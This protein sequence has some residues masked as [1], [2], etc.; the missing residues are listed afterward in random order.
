MKGFAFA[1]RSPLEVG[2]VV[3]TSTLLYPHTR[4]HEVTD[5]LVIHSARDGSA[6]IMYQLDRVNRLVPIDF[7][8]ARLVDGKP[9]PLSQEKAASKEVVL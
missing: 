4:A 9:V 7:I 3:V 6:R 2:D 1:V 8:A 5:I